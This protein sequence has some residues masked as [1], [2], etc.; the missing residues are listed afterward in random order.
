[1][2]PTYQVSSIGSSRSQLLA[3]LTHRHLLVWKRIDH[4]SVLGTL[5]WLH[6][7]KIFYQVSKPSPQAQASLSH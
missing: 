5:W 2:T 3:P 4:C 7:I 1:M 6:C